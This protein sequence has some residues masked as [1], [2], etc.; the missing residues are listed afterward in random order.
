[1]APRTPWHR[2]RLSAI[3]LAL[4]AGA[5]VSACGS[6]TK[7]LDSAKVERAIANSIAREHGLYTNVI[8]PA[9][10]PQRAGRAFTCTA[11]L[12]VGD[13]TVGVTETDGSGHVAYQSDSPL[14]ALDVAKVQR[15][16]E[17]SIFAQRGVRAKAACPAE[18]RQQ[19]GLAFRCTAAVNGSSQSYPFT[20]S[21]LDGAGDVRYIGS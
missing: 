7:T 16:I 21:Q 9:D 12:Q 14:I 17:A 1:M 4:V 18:V 19:A 8:C 10:I 13:Y 5:C 6:G 20:V 11:R 15:A 3:A 2:R